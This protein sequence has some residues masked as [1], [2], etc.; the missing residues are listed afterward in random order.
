MHEIPYVLDALD[1]PG[2]RDDLVHHISPLDLAAD[3]HDAADRVD[4]ELAL[5]QVLVAEDLALHAVGDRRVVDVL[6]V[7]IARY[8]SGDAFTRRR[9]GRSGVARQ[10]AEA[11]GAA[12]RDRTHAVSEDRA[13]SSS[14]P[15]VE[16][17]Q[18]CRAS[19]RT[20]RD[21]RERRAGGPLLLHTA[22]GD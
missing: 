20:E 5:G 9:E 4:V 12:P 21:R 7:A 15:W 11:M 10:S 16:E 14:H 1:A 17:V 19:D 3:H 2:S 13:P 8:L 18:G 6:P 22:L